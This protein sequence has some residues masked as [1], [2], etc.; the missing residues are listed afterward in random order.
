MKLTVGVENEDWFVLIIYLFLM[1]GKYLCFPVVIITSDL[2]YTRI[3]VD[4][5]PGHTAH[6]NDTKNIVRLLNTF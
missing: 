1:H 5:S 2:V 3:K 4:L 6:D